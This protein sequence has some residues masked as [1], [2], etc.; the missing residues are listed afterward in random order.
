MSDQMLI[1]GVPERIRSW[2]DNERRERMMTKK[3]FVIHTL[4]MAYHKVSGPSLFDEVAARPAPIPDSTPFTFTD[5]FAGIGGLRIA[6]QRCGGKCVFTSE[7]D[8]NAQKTY[9]RWFGDTPEGDITKIKPKDI[10]D[11]DVLAAGF[12]CQP[13]S[14]AGVSKKNSLGKAHGFKCLTQG[15][16][17]FNIIN[18]VDIK[19]PPVLFLENVKNLKSHDKGRT[20]EVISQ[21]LEEQKYWVFQEVLDA[22]D[23]GV[24]QHRERVFIICFDKHVFADKPPFEFPPPTAPKV[25]L[26][27]ILEDSVDARYT[28]TSH[29]WNYLQD[30]ATRHAAKAWHF[31]SSQMAA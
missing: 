9:A 28:L 3:E 31:A 16:L 11:H 4:E 7:W 27:E 23:F 25:K 22:A 21:S 2:I 17:F 6:L 5:L 15:T 26:R 14:I 13:F 18:I 8:K 12:P 24:P 29:P 10:P 1:K 19:R 20:W 30:Y